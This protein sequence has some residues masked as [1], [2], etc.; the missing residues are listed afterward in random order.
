MFLERKVGYFALFTFLVGWH[1]SPVSLPWVDVIIAKLA[2][3]LNDVMIF[4]I[5]N[6]Q[7]I[8]LQIVCFVLQELQDVS[9]TDSD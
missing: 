6:S 1:A 5:Q 9:W 2:Y 7:P 3:S 4:N 8:Y